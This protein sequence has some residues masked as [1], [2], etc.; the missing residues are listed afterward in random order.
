MVLSEKKFKTQILIVIEYTYK[1]RVKII[2][3]I[4]QLGKGFVADN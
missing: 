4:F 3:S 1:M 2:F